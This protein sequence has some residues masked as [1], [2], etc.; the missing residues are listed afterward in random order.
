MYP[1]GDSN[2][3][4]QEPIVHVGQYPGHPGNCW[5]HGCSCTP[6][7]ECTQLH[8]QF[9]IPELFTPLNKDE[10]V[11]N[12]VIPGLEFPVNKGRLIE[13]GDK[14]KPL[15]RGGTPMHKIIGMQ[16]IEAL[17]NTNKKYK[18]KMELEAEFRTVIRNE[19]NKMIHLLKT[20]GLSP[21]KIAG[22]KVIGMEGLKK[23]FKK[24]FDSI[25]SER[26]KSSK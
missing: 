25:S 26:V 9:E 7:N 18:D 23:H 1:V 19:S 3:D 24:A 12:L 22:V 14:D 11:F 2:S 13:L 17:P 6:L 10:F 4:E 21:S 8:R 5:K 16:L 15:D 20:Q